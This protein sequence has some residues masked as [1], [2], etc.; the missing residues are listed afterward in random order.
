MKQFIR[1]IAF[2]AVSIALFVGCNNSVSPTNDSSKPFII[3][4]VNKAADSTAHDFHVRILPY[5]DTVFAVAET[6]HYSD[7]AGAVVSFQSDTED[8]VWPTPDASFLY[9]RNNIDT[10]DCNQNGCKYWV[11]GIQVD[12]IVLWDI[13]FICSFMGHPVAV[14]KSIKTSTV[15]IGYPDDTVTINYRDSIATPAGTTR[16]NLLS[17]R[18]SVAMQSIDVKAVAAP[19]GITVTQVAVLLPSFGFS[20]KSGQA[21]LTIAVSSGV[22]A[23]HYTFEFGIKIDGKEYGNIPCAITVM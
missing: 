22:A 8:A 3:K 18:R 21:Y 5:C 11:N 23:G 10:T 4:L 20:Y 9:Q 13:G 19:T 15:A 2:L 14:A 7:T 16:N 1:C 6:L 17:I 12:T